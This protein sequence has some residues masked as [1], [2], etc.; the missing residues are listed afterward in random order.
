[1]ERRTLDLFPPHFGRVHRSRLPNRGPA[2]RVINFR[3]F[4]GVL[5]AN[6]E[7]S[8]SSVPTPQPVRSWSHL[9][10]CRATEKPLVAVSDDVV[11]KP[12]SCTDCRYA[13]SLGNDTPSTGSC[14]SLETD[15][16][17]PLATG[18]RDISTL[19]GGSVPRS[20]VRFLPY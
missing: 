19:A 8:G 11:A 18:T 5:A 6:S 15:W 10:E 12:C 4:V 3:R 1:M 7:R 16:L 2:S 13:C 17:A 20:I 14:E 9:S